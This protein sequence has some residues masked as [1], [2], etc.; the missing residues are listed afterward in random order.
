MEARLAPH[1][2]TRADVADHVAFGVDPSVIGDPARVFST[3]AAVVVSGIRTE[4]TELCRRS[5]LCAWITRRVRPL[6]PSPRD[7]L[8]FDPSFA[9]RPIPHPQSA[10]RAGKTAC[11]EVS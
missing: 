8:P 2:N 11:D 7:A 6:G 3:A 10:P 4:P 9:H 5:R 1:A